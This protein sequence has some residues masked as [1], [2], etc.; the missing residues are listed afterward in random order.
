MAR[1]IRL[2]FPNA[3]YHVMSRGNGGENIFIEDADKLA[4]L[5]L[6]EGLQIRY[7]VICYAYCLM[8]NH[9]H[10]LIETPKANLSQIKE[11][12][13]FVY[14]RNMLAKALVNPFPEK[15][16]NKPIWAMKLSLFEITQYYGVHYSTVSRAIRSFYAKC[17]D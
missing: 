7:D 17:N 5:G 9:Y 16:C 6:F 3:L 13:Q 14:I 15:L 12:R 10:L 1:P 4:F 11:K 2:E 8:D